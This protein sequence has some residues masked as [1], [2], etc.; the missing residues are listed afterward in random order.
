MSKYAKTGSRPLTVSS[1]HAREMELVVADAVQAERQQCIETMC[2]LC[3]LPDTVWL[4]TVER[5]IGVHRW[6]HRPKTESG[7]HHPEL[8]EAWPIHERVYQEGQG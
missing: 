8:C 2:P 4:Q 5:E 6:G 7:T 3:R 1:I